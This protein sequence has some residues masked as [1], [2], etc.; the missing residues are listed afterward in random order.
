MSKLT[1][2]SWGGGGEVGEGEGAERERRKGSG[3][4][5]LMLIALVRKKIL[6]SKVHLG[7]KSGLRLDSAPLG[8]YKT[9]FT[10][11]MY[12]TTSYL[13]LFMFVGFSCGSLSFVSADGIQLDHCV[14]CSAFALKSPG[15]WD[16]PIS[17][18]FKPPR[19]I[20]AVL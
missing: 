13:L 15:L 1:V 7:L 9:R 4:K 8:N 10:S 5:T 12:R 17:C 11:I 16:K 18:D 20:V 19:G 2:D 6:D 14:R 3:K